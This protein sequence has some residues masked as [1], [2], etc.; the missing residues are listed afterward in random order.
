MVQEIYSAASA[1]RAILTAATVQVQYF[2]S[3]SD[4]HPENPQE[5][6]LLFYYDTGMFLRYTDGAWLE[7]GVDIPVD[8]KIG[9]VSI[10]TKY[11]GQTYE[12][13]MF[14]TKTSSGWT[15]TPVGSIDD[16]DIPV[17]NVQFFQRSNDAAPSN[18]AV[19]N[20]MFY[21]D[22]SAFV[23][24]NGTAWV[25]IN[26]DT[27]LDEGKIFFS[28]RTTVMDGTPTNDPMWCIK[29]ADGWS[30]RQV[31]PP[32][33]DTSVG[34]W[35]VNSDIRPV[36]YYLTFYDYSKVGQ[37]GGVSPRIGDTII[38]V[39]NQTIWGTGF[40]WSLNPSGSINSLVTA[41]TDP[42]AILTLVDS[43]YISIKDRVVNGE[44]FVPLSTHDGTESRVVLESSFVWA[45]G[46]Q[47]ALTDI[48]RIA[49]ATDGVSLMITQD[50]MTA[51]ASFTNPAISYQAF[52]LDG[53]FSL[54]IVISSAPSGG[55]N[56][57]SFSLRADADGNI[58]E[59][60]TMNTFDVTA[61]LPAFTKIQHVYAI[62]GDGSITETLTDPMLAA[63]ELIT[64]AVAITATETINADMLDKY[65]PTIVGIGNAKRYLAASAGQ[66]PY[67]DEAQGGV[68]DTDSTIVNMARR[69]GSWVPTSS[70]IRLETT[71]VDT[72]PVGARASVVVEGTLPTDL[73]QADDYWVERYDFNYNASGIQRHMQT[74][75]A[76]RDDQSRIQMFKRMWKADTLGGAG[77]W[78]AWV[79]FYDSEEQPSADYV[80][81][82]SSN[83][84][85][86]TRIHGLWAPSAS[87][88]FVTDIELDTQPAGQ[89]IAGSTVSDT[90]PSGI[91]PNAGHFHAVRYDLNFDGSGAIRHIQTLSAIS[92]DTNHMQ[93]FKRLYTQESSASQGVWHAW[94]KVYDS[95]LDFVT[96]SNSPTTPMARLEGVWQLQHCYMH[97]DN[98]NVDAV[99]YNAVSA[100]AVS[101]TL[102]TGI[103][104]NADNYF[105]TTNSINADADMGGVQTLTVLTS[106]TGRLQEYKRFILTSGATP[107]RTVYD[108]NYPDA[109]MGEWLFN[110]T[111]SAVGSIL[112]AEDTA[113]SKLGTLGASAPQLG[114]GVILTKTDGS[115]WGY[116][117]ITT[118]ASN[119]NSVA[120]LSSTLTLVAGQGTVLTGNAIDIKHD[121]TLI[122]DAN[123][124]LSVVGSE[125]P[126][127]NLVVSVPGGF[128]V[129]A[130]VNL[131][132]IDYREFCGVLGM[133]TAPSSAAQ[134]QNA[135][136]HPID[137]FTIVKSTLSPM[138]KTF[139][140]E[141]DWTRHYLQELDL[142]Y[143]GADNSYNEWYK[144]FRQ[145]D[146]TPTAFQN[147]TS[148]VLMS[149]AI[150]PNGGFANGDYI[151]HVDKQGDIFTRS[152][153]I[154][155]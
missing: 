72:M 30:Y 2:Q 138:A 19:N 65:L 13:P 49:A 134:I 20:V 48:N 154:N 33:V 110:A 15:V 85:H 92:V 119:T 67:W 8:S 57:A 62:N 122:I 147:V 130:M 109:S 116:G 51:P 118:R 35:E 98:I 90:P 44:S 121:A 41:S 151:E 126:P 133:C 27:T 64:H 16:K 91:D 93:M 120:V 38:Y 97:T 3:S 155:T 10:C 83:L 102:P 73:M 52:V 101:G 124:Q 152:F 79:L 58:I 47:I 125:N 21:S 153:Q 106:S 9:M 17:V 141:T 29:T 43:A 148:W 128:N 5:D 94:I 103:D 75:T 135:T 7:R 14:V 115:Y 136:G 78:E 45:M 1:R 39:K 89:E 59:C 113:M 11:D 81:D 40:V 4:A 112:S 140:S 100:S 77:T 18:P 76:A 95:A 22:T 145:G 31:F 70:C 63:C 82:T 131:P 56:V 142:F 84:T 146:E 42:E 139:T 26:V 123:N 149:S 28:S 127:V 105:V 32:D 50:E 6:A 46:H 108:S 37:Y 24:W 111:V 150:L 80:V 25:S 68:P 74:L 53:I 117:K 129:D 88:N 23:Q 60:V 86:M 143:N 87:C 107:W 96:D 71:N 66:E 61:I 12:M 137:A 36:D 99:G 69:D 104:T 144:L 55:E 114:D 34:I 132:D 54:Y